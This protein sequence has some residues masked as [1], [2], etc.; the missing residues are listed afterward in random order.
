MPQN[1]INSKYVEFLNEALS[2]ENAAV[3]RITSRIN[4]TPIPELK[5]RLHQ[6]LEE[7]HNQQERLA[8]VITRLGGKPT[9]SKA[10]LPM[11]APPATTPI[12]KTAKDSLESITNDKKDNP[13]SEEM[14]LMQ[15][16]Q[17]T[18]VEGAEIVGYETLIEIT[19]KIDGLPNDEI[20]P[21]IKQSF[22][23]EKDLHTWCKNNIHMEVEVLLQKI[24]SAIDNYSA[25]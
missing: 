25:N 13:L 21:A 14:E 5:Q 1:D 7:T 9:E 15:L 4:Q 3:E 22:Q 17:D 23:E 8:Q 2:A 16:K 11:L 18:L 20:L 19:Q 24:L 12:K 10:Q 6:H